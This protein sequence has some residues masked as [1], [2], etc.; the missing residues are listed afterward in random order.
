MSENLISISGYRTEGSETFENVSDEK[1]KLIYEILNPKPK[2][3][4]EPEKKKEGFLDNV[5]EFFESIN[6]RI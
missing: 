4:K 3:I 6:K 1:M 2:K 5:E